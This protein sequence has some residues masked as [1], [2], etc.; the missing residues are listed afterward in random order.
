MA[1]VVLPT[2]YP[3]CHPT[4]KPLRRPKRKRDDDDDSGDGNLNRNPN[5][6]QPTAT[7][8]L[9]PPPPPCSNS[10]PHCSKD[11]YAKALGQFGVHLPV[12]YYFSPSIDELVGYYLLRRINGTLLT[13]DVA[14]I[15]DSDVYGDEEPWEIWSRFLDDH[16]QSLFLLTR[17]KKRS[18]RIGTA[19]GT[20]HEESKKRHPVNG[21][22]IK[23]VERQFTYRN[24][25]SPKTKF[26]W[27][28]KEFTLDNY[29]S[30]FAVCELRKKGCNSA[31]RSPDPD[32]SFA[33]PVTSHLATQ[34]VLGCGFFHHMFVGPTPTFVK[35]K[36]G[37]LAPSRNF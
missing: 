2:H 11:P 9:S 20:W 8:P 4:P 34:S 32:P 24:I 27:L 12:G 3:S 16:C 35:R 14:L 21:M 29:P 33:P 19:G 37:K 23:A 18:R 25:S 5:P 10:L 15:P 22:I 31:V 30:D 13:V 7:A 26:P 1:Q 17:L 28:V 36:K 6:H